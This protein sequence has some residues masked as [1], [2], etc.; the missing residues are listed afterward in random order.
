MGKIVAEGLGK[1]FHLPFNERADKHAG[2]ATPIGSLTRSSAYV[3]A[4][5]I[6]SNHKMEERNVPDHWS[7]VRL[8]ERGWKRG[9]D[10]K[11]TLQ[12]KEKRIYTQPE[13]IEGGR[14]RDLQA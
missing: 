9:A 3:T 11:V 1:A 7:V 2:E 5:A 6:D 13:D 14:K 12:G 10:T 8:K 4:A